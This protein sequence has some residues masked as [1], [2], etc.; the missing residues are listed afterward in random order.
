MR[1]LPVSRAAG[2]PRLPAATAGY[3]RGPRS[4]RRFL[5]V[6]APWVAGFAGADVLAL[7]NTVVGAVRSRWRSLARRRGARAVPRLGRSGARRVGGAVAVAA[8]VVLAQ[9]GLSTLRV[10]ASGSG[11]A[12]CAVRY[13]RV[14]RP[15][16]RRGRPGGA[17]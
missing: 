10:D 4:A 14:D 5:P 17:R 13:A 12:R 16:A 11:R 2:S 8:V 15:A 3:N 7:S 6:L 1:G 9:A